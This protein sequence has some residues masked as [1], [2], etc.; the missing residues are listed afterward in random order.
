MN[1]SRD[2]L[3]EMLDYA[4]L[5]LYID[6]LMLQSCYRLNIGDYAVI[7]SDNFNE[8]L[9]PGSFNEGIKLIY[10]GEN[11]NQNIEKGIL[12]STVEHV[13]LKENFNKRI[14]CFSPLTKIYLEKEKESLLET[15]GGI[16][17]WKF[18]EEEKYWMLFFETKQ[19]VHTYKIQSIS[20]RIGRR[21]T[22]SLPV[23]KERYSCLSRDD[24]IHIIAQ[25]TPNVKESFG[26]GICLVSKTVCKTE[27]CKQALCPLCFTKI[28]LSPNFSCPYCR[29][30]PVILKES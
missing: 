14:Y 22:I 5:D 4:I 17:C 3:L 25:T 6:N 24:L 8:P 11:F 20:H 18:F 30:N 27:C 10:F 1:N 23:V 2:L 16:F 13:F 21:S 9:R 28:L 29:K 26:C 19:H 15:D 12:P 7:F